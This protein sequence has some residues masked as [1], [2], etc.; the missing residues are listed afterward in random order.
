MPIIATCKNHVGHN[1]FVL[2]YYGYGWG[3]PDLGVSS[4]SV[5]ESLEPEP[6][7]LHMKEPI[8]CNGDLMGVSGPVREPRHQYDKFWCACLLRRTDE[9]DF[10]THP[11]DYLVY[12]A[13]E[14]LPMHPAPYPQKALGQWVVFDK[15][16]FCLCG[17]ATVAESVQWVQDV[18]Q[19]T[20]DSRKRV[21]EQELI[22]ETES[23]PKR[24]PIGVFMKPDA[25]WKTLYDAA[26][27]LHAA[28]RWVVDLVRKPYSKAVQLPV[29]KEPL[30]EGCVYR[31]G[32]EEI[33]VGGDYLAFLEEQIKLEPR[34]EL[35]ADVLKKRLGVLSRHLERKVCYV[36]LHRFTSGFIQSCRIVLNPRDL[37]IIYWESS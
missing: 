31:P 16:E 25:I 35:W 26:E 37:S 32:F 28:P 11:G 5:L 21:E 6:F 17:Y 15:S 20:M 19:R 27:F 36:T 24:V 3:R 12:I 14:A 34:G 30:Q 10:T 23:S 13:K 7:H 2:P 9:C 4:T 1:L 18:Y 8:L 29:F 33:L 22:D